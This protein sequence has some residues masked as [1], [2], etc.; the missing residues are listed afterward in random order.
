MADD[1]SGLEQSAIRNAPI[2]ISQHTPINVS[3]SIEHH[4]ANFGSPNGKPMTGI[5][6]KP[7]ETQSAASIRASP[8]QERT[9]NRQHNSQAVLKNEPYVGEDNYSDNQ[10]DEL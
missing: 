1:K 10:Y 7:H 9:L 8:N 3:Q 4:E 6:E 2:N 5:L